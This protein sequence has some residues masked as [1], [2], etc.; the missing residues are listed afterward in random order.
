MR[1]C[2]ADE[3]GRSMSALSS[4]AHVAPGGEPLRDA[5]PFDPAAL[6]VSPDFEAV[7]VKS[8]MVAVPVRK[9]KRQ[10]FI[11]VHPDE[12]YRLETAV[13]ELTEEHE[14]LYPVAASGRS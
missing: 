8:V 1:G 4:K 2:A 9:P 12:R 11:R 6:R 13:I 5:D 3:E 10:E 14:T 7:A